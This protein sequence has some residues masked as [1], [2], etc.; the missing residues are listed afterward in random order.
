LYEIRVSGDDG[1][2]QPWDGKSTGEIEI[3]GPI[4]AGEYFEN[5]EGT[6]EKIDGGWLRTGDVGSMSHDGWLRITDRT[7]DVIKSGGGMDLVG[8]PRIGAHGTSS[9]SRGRCDCPA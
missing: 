3:R 2:V 8:R 5:P 4:V 7:K 9:S 6:A 1:N